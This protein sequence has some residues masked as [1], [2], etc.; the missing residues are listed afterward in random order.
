[1][2]IGILTQPLQANYG[3]LLQN[4]ALQQVLLRAGHE[5]ETI[6]WTPSY[7]SLRYRLYRI[8]WTILSFLF[9]KKFP[10]LKYQP[11]DDEKKVIQQHTNHFISTYIHHTKTIMFKDGF[12]HQAKVGK[13]DAY[14]VG[15][16]QCWRPCYN[17]FLS[18]M[19]LDFAKDEKVKRIA[20]AASFGTDQWEF[21]QEMTSICTPLAQKFNF[22]SVR[23]Y[24]GIKLC[25]EH[26]GV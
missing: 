2:K 22:V 1:M 12:R 20:Y 7:K 19:F 11:T 9:P 6:D 18:S 3:G 15:S 10:K 17:A 4:Y 21:T 25:K 5:V 13:Y 16:D 14:V 24:S 8:K 26:L 23:E